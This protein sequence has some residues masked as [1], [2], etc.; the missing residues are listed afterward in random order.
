MAEPSTHS[1]GEDDEVAA[2][3]MPDAPTAPAEAPS[4]MP[5]GAAAPIEPG[6][7]EPERTEG[8]AVAGFVVSLVSLVILPTLLAIIGFILSII[9]LNRVNQSNGRLGG[10]GLAIAGIVISVFSF[11]VLT[12]IWIPV[13]VNIYG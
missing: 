12:A 9:G 7:V 8:M 13:L 3:A 11:I 2:T 5:V 6:R 4:E 1:L 10:K